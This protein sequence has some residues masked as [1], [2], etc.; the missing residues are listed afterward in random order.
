MEMWKKAG[1]LVIPVIPGVALARRLEGAGADAVT[2]EGTESGG[3]VGEMTTM[4]LVPQVIDAVDVP[5]IAA[6]GHCRRTSG[7]G[8]AGAGGLRHS[9]GNMSSGKPGMPDS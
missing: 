8:G 2:A 6:G 4:A 3:H 1:C 5:V 9:G 7:C